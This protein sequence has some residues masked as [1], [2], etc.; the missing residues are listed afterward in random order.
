MELGVKL[1][2][3]AYVLNHYNLLPIILLFKSTYEKGKKKALMVLLLNLV[4]MRFQ[5]LRCV[6][7]MC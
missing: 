2:S 1:R 6:F 4:Y 5:S 7:R 3:K